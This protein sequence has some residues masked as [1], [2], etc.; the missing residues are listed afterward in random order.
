MKD[1]FVLKLDL[2]ESSLFA[3]EEVQMVSDFLISAP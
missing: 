3:F 1:P 2:L